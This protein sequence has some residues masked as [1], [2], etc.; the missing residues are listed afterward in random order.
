[1][2]APTALLVQLRRVYPR[3]LSFLCSYRTSFAQLR[4]SL[5]L[6]HGATSRF[7]PGAT[8][9]VVFTRLTI[10]ASGGH[11]ASNF[12]QTTSS[13][14]WLLLA[15]LQPP[16]RKTNFLP[17]FLFVSTWSPNLELCFSRRSLFI[18]QCENQSPL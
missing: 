2:W 18:D 6:A 4:A 17:C 15:S 16:G 8:L 12:D 7:W 10:P 9:T 11:P 1:H 14:C 13:I 3:G 5:W